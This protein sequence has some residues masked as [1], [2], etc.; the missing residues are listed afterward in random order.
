MEFPPLRSGGGNYGD[1]YKSAYIFCS[2]PVALQSPCFVPTCFELA[3]HCRFTV[4]VTMM[5]SSTTTNPRPEQNKSV[6]DKTDAQKKIDADKVA[7]D[8]A[9]AKA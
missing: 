8:A 9:K 5:P 1:T 4:G 3:N 7:A 2:P 6:A